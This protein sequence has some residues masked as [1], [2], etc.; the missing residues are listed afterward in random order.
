MKGVG[1]LGSK[2]DERVNEGVRYS[3]QKYKIGGFIYSIFTKVVL[4]FFTNNVVIVYFT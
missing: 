1:W 4:L 2:E 3:F